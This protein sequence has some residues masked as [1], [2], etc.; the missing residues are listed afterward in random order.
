MGCGCKGEKISPEMINQGTGELNLKGKLLKLPLALLMTLLIVVISPIILV[1][2]W[3]MAINSVFGKDRNVIDLLL[4]KNFK[5]K[6][7]EITNTEEEDDF[8]ED[9]YEMVGI[10]IIK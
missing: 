1:I 3:Y 9:D 2:V 10:D 4:F 8:N 6:P 7:E 5:K